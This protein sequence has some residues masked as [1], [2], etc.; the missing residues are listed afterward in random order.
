MRDLREG[1]VLTEILESRRESRLVLVTRV[2]RDVTLDGSS[3]GPVALTV[4]LLDLETGI[5]DDDMRGWRE[6]RLNDPLSHFF[7]SLWDGS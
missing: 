1:D 7:L 5:E 3:L 6:Y 2:V 4:Q